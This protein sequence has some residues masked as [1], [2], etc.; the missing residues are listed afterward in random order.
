MELFFQEHDYIFG[1]TRVDM[2]IRLRGCDR[3]RQ[4]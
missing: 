3:K 1:G 2:G 4:M